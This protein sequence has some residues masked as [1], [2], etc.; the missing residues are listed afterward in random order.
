MKLSV[1]LFVVSLVIPISAFSDPGA[2]ERLFYWYAYTM[3][4]ART[5]VATGCSKSVSSKSPCTFSQFMKY[6]DMNPEELHENEI[7]NVDTT[8]VQRTVCFDI[9]VGIFRLTVG[10]SAHL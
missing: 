5:K 1:F 7:K 6:I 3:D 8:D 10:S 9:P 2:Y 4:T